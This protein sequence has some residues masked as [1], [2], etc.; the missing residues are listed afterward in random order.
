MKIRKSS[1]G[2]PHKAYHLQHNHSRLQSW[3]GRWGVPQSWTGE[4]TP[5]TDMG[6]EIGVPPPPPPRRWW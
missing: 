6:L 4:I 3:P 2:K 5:R 1:C